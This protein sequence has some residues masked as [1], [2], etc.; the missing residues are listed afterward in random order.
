MPWEYFFC[1]ETCWEESATY[2][3]FEAEAE[4]ILNIMTKDHQDSLLDILEHK[5]K[6]DILI[7]M[8]WNSTQAWK[9]ARAQ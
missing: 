9:K 3:E 7:D 4:I 5:D 1:T 6:R 8:L 2:A